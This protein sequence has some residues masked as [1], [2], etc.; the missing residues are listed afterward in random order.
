[1]ATNTWQNGGVNTNWNTAGNWT[2]GVPTADDNVVLPAG[3]QD[4][5]INATA[6]C[7][8]FDASAYDR[9][10]THNAGI[11]LTIGDGTAGASNVA[12]A[13]NA[14][15][16]MT[17]TL[18][19]VTTSAIT[20]ISTSTTAQTVNFNG[21]KLGNLTFNGVGGS[22]Q[23]TGTVSSSATDGAQ[24]L[25]FLNGTLDTNGQ[26]VH[27]GK[28]T[29]YTTS[30]R[31][32]T[33]GTS[34]INTYRYDSGWVLGY[35]GTITFSGA[36]STIVLNNGGVFTGYQ[37]TYGTV[38]FTGT[39]ETQ[40][41]ITD[42][43]NT[44]ATLNVTGSAAKTPRF[45]FYGNNTI[46]GTLN[47]DGNS[48]INRIL[49]TSDTLGT[50]RT[51]TLT[52][53]TVS[54]C[55]NVDFRDITFAGSP[56]FSGITGG[57]GDC[58]GNTGATFTTADDWYWYSAGAGT[59][60]W[61]DY[62]Y[63]YTETAGGGSQM[64]STRT[65]LPQDN[66]FLDS[67]SINGTTTIDQDLPRVC[68]TADFTNVDA[69]GWHINNIS[70]TFYGGLILVNNVT[71]TVT[72]GVELIFGGRSAFN[73]NS[74]GKTVSTGL[75]IAMVGG[76][77]TLL[78]DLNQSTRY[79]NHSNGTFDAD[80]YNVTAGQYNISGTSLR[81]TYMGSGTWTLSVSGTATSWNAGTT[82]N[83]TFD[84]EQS[85][86]V[87][88]NSGTGVSDIEG[89]NLTYNNFTAI[90]GTGGSITIKGSNAFNVFT[91]LSPRTLKFTAGT[92]TTVSSF[93]ATGDAGNLIHI[94]STSASA[95]TLTD[96]SGTNTVHY[97][98]IGET[99][100]VNAAATGT[101]WD[102]TDNCQVNSSTGWTTASAGGFMTCNSKFWSIF[103]LLFFWC[104]PLFAQ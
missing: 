62:T 90:A 47:I 36:S 81:R 39:T 53:A 38:T 8:S 16:S 41:R 104:S 70:Q 102:A 74:E 34:T 94:D 21:H 54:G 49:V 2:D 89:G 35:S 17:Y 20:F 50:P 57:S 79:I 27:C 72:N 30:N 15:S 63:W 51:I 99:G 40:G 68:K 73:Y 44:I 60:N 98:H 83:L 9:T 45:L 31:T 3:T 19:S 7:R 46:T 43:G 25:S 23:L 78:S 66:A 91:I 93:V 56:D 76:S 13:F 42:Y 103:L 59:Y 37:K 11:S 64:A 86:I 80:I 87:F 55:S 77:L 65:I 24:I 58:G 4:M 26:T 71:L 29:S 28:F 10:I 96:P 5:T 97:C 84:A 12:L 22:W 69:V 100:A 18:G 67:S 48:S 32:L 14:T 33:L 101:T 6:V 52:G 1:M 75:T 88:G 61:S 92:T 82:T 95:A 85:S